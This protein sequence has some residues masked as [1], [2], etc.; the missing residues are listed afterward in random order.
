MVR[1]RAAVLFTVPPSHF[2]FYLSHSL[3]G[4]V[5]RVGTHVRDKTG[6]V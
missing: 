5:Y 4:K 3:I 6:L 1:T 2:G